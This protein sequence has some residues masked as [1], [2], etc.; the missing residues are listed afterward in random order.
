MPAGTLFYVLK[1]RVDTP[2][3]TYTYTYTLQN[4]IY[5]FYC[6]IIFTIFF[7]NYVIKHKKQAHTAPHVRHQTSFA[8]QIIKPTSI[9]PCDS[10]KYK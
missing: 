4:Y 10:E 8:E 2:L 1:R 7:K 3:A 5:F 6:T 9:I